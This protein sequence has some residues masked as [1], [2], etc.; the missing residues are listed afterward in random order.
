L[1]ATPAFLPAPPSD[2]WTPSTG[3]RARQGHSAG[4]KTA[5]EGHKPS[6]EDPFK[7][8]YRL[9]GYVNE[10][11]EAFKRGIEGVAASFG[12]K[13]WGSKLV[14]PLS[15]Y[16][17]Y[18]YSGLNALW[19][20]KKE[21]D[22]NSD[23]DSSHRAYNS[24]SKGLDTLAFQYLASVE[25]P[26]FIVSAARVGMELGLGIAKEEHT[27]MNPVQKLLHAT[28]GKPTQWVMQKAGEGLGK[29]AIVQ[30][31]P[32]LKQSLPVVAALALIPLCIK[33]VDAFSEWLLNVSFRPASKWL[34]RQFF[35]S[36][37]LKY[38][39]G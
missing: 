31:Y 9:V 18:A 5:L 27:K 32:M 2:T 21:Y 34:E 19:A 22:E 6:E 3:D 23:L 8:K 25:I 20:G 29:L 11:A 14:N 10:V 12:K 38:E 35:G 33:P 4:E 15:Y 37:R 16:V 24:T 36:N 30:R 1:L 17:V 28:V 7:T 13:E 26:A 39:E